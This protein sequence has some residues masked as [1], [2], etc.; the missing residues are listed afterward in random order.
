MTQS[1]ITIFYGTYGGLVS[2]VYASEESCIA[3]RGKYHPFNSYMEARIFA[4]TG[5]ISTDNAEDEAAGND[6]SEKRVHFSDTDNIKDSTKNAVEI[7]DSDMEG[8]DTRDKIAK[9]SS[10]R[11]T[12]FALRRIADNLEKGDN[13]KI[14]QEIKMLN[15]KLSR[16]KVESTSNGDRMSRLHKISTE[17]EDLLSLMR[18]GFNIVTEK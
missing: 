9:D 6:I 12:A 13:D 4:C 7:I 15:D 2:G 17:I 5:I 11:E 18:H 10:K 1:Q 3:S 8:K 14:E 16:L